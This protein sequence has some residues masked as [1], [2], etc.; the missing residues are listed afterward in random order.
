MS[1]L[2]TEEQ[3]AIRTTAREFVREKL[4]IAQLRALRDCKD[5]TGF[6]RSAWSEMAGLGLAGAVLPEAHGGAG[7]GY[8]ELGLVLEECGR[9][10]AA[11]PMLSTVVL[12]AGALVL[13]GTKEQ[14]TAW[15][16]G[17]AGG[18]KLLAFAHDEGTRFAPYAVTTRFDAQ[19]LLLDGEKAFVFDGHVADAFVVVARSA[20]K[21]GDCDGLTLLLV[22]KG[23]K[24]VSVERRWM[25]DSHNSAR[26]RFEGV[27]VSEAQIIGRKGAGADVL[28]PLLD[29]AA[30]ALASEM[31]GGA[32]EAL[33]RTVQYLKTR[34]QFGALIGTFQ[35]LKH[36]AATMFCEVELLR[37]VVLEALR[38]ID[39]GRAD[40]PQLASVA[41]A[42]A[43][44]VFVH[45]A[46]EAIQMHGGIGVTDEFDIGLYLKRAR[47]AEMSFGS[48]SYHRD[49]FGRLGGY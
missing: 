49:R 26:V 8:A 31:L 38:A 19:R 2:L 6:S 42:R 24:G 21:P 4:P 15:L 43:S 27:S 12:G 1:L 48:A 18:E 14:Q 5:E 7:L 28:D 40:V 13:G 45:V 9:T 41:K 3:E 25:V 44:D 46:N 47:A 39:E 37:S 34:K 20:G 23:A 22:P 10:L 36:R 35:A 16:P 32:Q 30:V 33:D 11:T 29:C 17:V